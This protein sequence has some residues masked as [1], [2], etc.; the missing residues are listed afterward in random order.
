MLNKIEIKEIM[1][2]RI[3]EYIVIICLNNNLKLKKNNLIKLLKIFLLIN[4]FFA[5]LQ[6]MKLI[7]SISSLGYLDTNNS[8][9]LRSF[10]IMGGSWELAVTASIAY[11]G[12]SN[13]SNKKNLIFYFFITIILL[14][15]A[16]S[17]TSIFAFIISCLILHKDHQSPYVRN[18]R[19]FSS[20]TA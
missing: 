13:M 16:N 8:L 10:G 12:L 7:G 18:M 11:L 6:N 1:I 9:N 5:L 4:F 20:D 14:Y 15:L 19:V 2:I 17:R 3:F